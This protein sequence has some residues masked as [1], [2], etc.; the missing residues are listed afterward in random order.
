MSNII[1]ELSRSNDTNSSS[2]N[3]NWNNIFNPINVNTG[4]SISIKNT[5]LDISDNND[6]N[7]EIDE[8]TEIKIEFYYYAVSI[9]VNN[10]QAYQNKGFAGG[11]TGKPGIM[12]NIAGI[13]GTEPIFTD[14]TVGSVSFTLKKGSYSPSLIATT[15][16]RDF[17][18]YNTPETEDVSF[19][20][21]PLTTNFDDIS[22]LPRYFKDFNQDTGVNQD[23][24][25]WYAYPTALFVG[26]SEIAL[27]FNKEGN[28]RFSFDYL[29]TPLF[30]WKD[31][32]DESIILYNTNTGGKIYDR[33]SGIVFKSLSPDSFWKKQLGFDTDNMTIS[34]TSTPSTD[35]PA[36]R[37]GINYQLTVN[38]PDGLDLANKKSGELTKFDMIT[39]KNLPTNSSYY[40]ALKED[41]IGSIIP[42]ADITFRPSQNTKSILAN[43]DYTSSIQSGFYLVEFISK[44]STQYNNT[45]N[46]FRNISA[47]VPRQYNSNS[48]VTGY[49]DISIPY[50]HSGL[51]FTLSGGKI[52]ILDGITKEEV[53][54]GEKS[55]VMLQITKDHNQ[56]YEEPEN[57]KEEPKKPK[58]VLKHKK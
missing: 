6:T 32:G 52:R 18:K 16:S 47:I 30:D 4:D 19:F 37:T 3:A 1:V 14:P 5:F 2:T 17:S 41:P 49:S 13:T 20:N 22:L 8:D 21:G 9:E 53:S 33:H 15:I 48:I 38:F 28:N 46:I 43:K 29:H 40:T 26:A 10:G 24:Y 58:L 39:T 55:T 34:I 54:L 42:A 11:L 7:I 56:P 25:W 35:P 44:Y 12:C 27:T 51:P 31:T 23:D 50:L 57:D 45:E 36:D